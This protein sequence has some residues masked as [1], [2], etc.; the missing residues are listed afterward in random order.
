MFLTLISFKNLL[1]YRYYINGFYFYNFNNSLIN[2]FL[3]FIYIILSRVINVIT[4]YN[5]YYL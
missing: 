3:F 5:I 4:T 1:Y 2:I